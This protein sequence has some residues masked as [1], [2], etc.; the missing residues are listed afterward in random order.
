MTQESATAHQ[1]PSE[2]LRS[3][4]HQPNPPL[5]CGESQDILRRL[6]G[7][8]NDNRLAWPFIPFPENLLV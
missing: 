8:A 6:L 2:A 4:G 3:V 5:E 7:A 1:Y